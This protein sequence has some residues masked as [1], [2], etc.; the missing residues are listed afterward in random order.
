MKPNDLSQNME[1]L[2]LIERKIK[3]DVCT[4]ASDDTK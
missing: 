1:E 4:I 2:F 3:H